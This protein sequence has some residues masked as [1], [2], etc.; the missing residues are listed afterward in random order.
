MSNISEEPQLTGTIP[1]S[2]AGRLLHWFGLELLR[3][4][5]SVEVHNLVAP[6]SPR[7][8]RCRKV[9]NMLEICGKYHLSVLLLAHLFN[10][11]F[12]YTRTQFIYTHTR[13]HTQIYVYNLY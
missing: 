10:F 13:T 5:S 3:Q 12:C 7:P 9:G 1:R 11:F 4:T 8:K 6:K 2:A